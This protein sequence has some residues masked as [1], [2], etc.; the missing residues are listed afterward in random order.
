MTYW[1]FPRYV[2]V[3]EKRARAEKKLKQL[4]K[5][6]PA[7]RP[8]RIEG[9]AIA[10]T[11][12]GKAWNDNLE[13]YADYANRIGR[14]R[15]YVRHRAVLD[16]QIE[17]GRVS[18]LVQGSA[19]RPYRVDIAI[20]ALDQKTWTA[21]KTA[22]AGQLD[23]LQDLLAGRFPQTLARIFTARGRGLFPAPDEIR[24]NC[25]CPDW[26]VMCKHVAAA[27]YGIGARLDEEPSLFFT[28]RKVRMDELVAETVRETTGQ[29]LKKATKKRKRVIADADLA[30]VFGIVMEDQTDFGQKIAPAGR[31][32]KAAPRKG[33]KKK[34]PP[35]A[36]IAPP[37]PPADDRTRV[38]DA[39]ARFADGVDVPALHRQTGVDLVKIRNIVYGACRKGL[40]ERVSRGVYRSKAVR[41]PPVEAVLQLIDGAVG[42]IAIG[43][44]QRIAN[45]PAAKIRAIVSLACRRGR[46]DRLSRGIYGPKRKNV[47]RPSAADAVL[48]I[49]AA[50]KKG[51]RFPELKEKT[52]FEDRKL[53]NIIFRL[54]KVNKIKSA[55]RGLYVATGT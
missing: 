3:A 46:I 25:S 7:V 15:S 20:E 41:Q 13:R 52:G 16:L 34:T 37:T 32:V 4:K 48:S 1:Q 50:A 12:W 11:W 21:V 24:L 49:I 18:A 45:L 5:K 38:L 40:V 53:R 28:L 26:A 19:A 8:V 23:S 22:C 29:L 27:L 35:A 39:V 6:N 47:R 51:I 44:L 30:D 42:G 43:E 14:G 55:A 17:P 36:G 9:R 31:A 2:S 10:R 33:R 54:S